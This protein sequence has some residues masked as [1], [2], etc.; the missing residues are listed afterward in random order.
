MQH[1]IFRGGEANNWYNRNKLG[2]TDNYTG[3]PLLDYLLPLDLVGKKILD[4]GCGNGHR[5]ARLAELGAECWGVEPSAKAVEEGKQRFPKLF[6]S[7]GC[8]HDLRSFKDEGF[9]LVTVSFVFHWVDRARLIQTVSE[10]DRVLKDGG[11]LAIQ[12]FYPDVPHKRP[13]H[14]DLN[15]CIYT[16]KQ[17]YAE[18]FL[19]TNLYTQIFRAN[20]EHP[21]GDDHSWHK[22]DDSLK[23]NDENGY[24]V[25]MKKDLQ[26]NYPIRDTDKGI[27]E[28][29]I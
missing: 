28:K 17:Q 20:F 16:Y 11:T 12:D 15:L 29:L 10:I 9:D 3:D 23:G 1:D 7:V 6:L 2:L 21:K 13:Y 27:S 25:V 4:I 19:A 8:S 26:G 5:L 14:H 18:M 22:R 24:L